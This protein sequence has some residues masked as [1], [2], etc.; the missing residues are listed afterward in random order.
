MKRELN[1]LGCFESVH[2]S[3]ARRMDGSLGVEKWCVVKCNALRG[4]GRREYYLGKG[5]PGQQ[6]CCHCS[7]TGEA[8]PTTELSAPRPFPHSP[9]PESGRAKARVGVVMGIRMVEARRASCSPGR[10]DAGR[11]GVRLC[12]N[13][14]LQRAGRRAGGALRRR[15]T[16]WKGE[17]GVQWG[18]F[19]HTG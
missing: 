17:E 10:R 14:F 4:P 7:T 11:K 12:D 2:R 9:I 15:R 18:A 8:R 1:R 19:D 13:D 3:R 16:S 6:G 5:G